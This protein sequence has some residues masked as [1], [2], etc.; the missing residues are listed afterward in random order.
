MVHEVVEYLGGR[1][2]VVDMTLGAGGHTEALLD[3]GV[4]RVV[5]VDRDP[6]AIEIA[7]ERLARFGDRFSPIRARFSEAELPEGIGGVLYDLGLSSM[8]LEAPG[9]GF[10]L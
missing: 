10:S 1:G 5:G 4:E 7:S 8:Q 6:S 3:A 9:S 2:T